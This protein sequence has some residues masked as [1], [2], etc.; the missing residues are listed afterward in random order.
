MQHLP[1]NTG[2]FINNEFVESVSKKK[3]KVINP[4]DETVMCEVAEGDKEDIDIAVSAAQKC[5]KEKWSK[6]PLFERQ[7]LLYKL[8]DL[9][10][11]DAKMLTELECVTNGTPFSLE[12]PV[13][14]GL[15]HTIRYNAGWM[16]KVDGRMITT[17]GTSHVFT[18]YSPLGVCGLVIPWNLPLWTLVVKLAPC[19][20]MG[21]TCV[22]KPSEKT[23]ITAL[24]FAE[25]IVEAGFPPGAVNIV[26]GYGQTAGAAL[27][28]H[29]D[30]RK[31]AFTGSTKV[32]KQ[33]MKYSAE[34]NLK[35]V[36]LELGGK[37]PVIIAEDADLDV[38]V[39]IAC[40][41]IFSNNGEICI[42]GSRTFVHENVYDEFIKKA[43]E[44]MTPWAVGDPLKSHLGPLVDK[45]QFETVLNYIK[46]GKDEGAKLE[47][48]GERQGEKGYFVKPTIFSGVTKE[49]KI[50]KEEIFGPVMSVIK[51][52]S[53][54][55]AVE[56]ANDTEYG[57]AAAIVTKDMSTAFEVSSAIEAGTVWVNTTHEVYDQAPFGGK[58]QSG[59]GKEGGIEGLL[60]WSN[61]KTVVM[62]VNPTLG[63]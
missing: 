8:A 56:M 41:A 17:N 29:M 15:V 42:A 50:C 34:S 31:L 3:F 49:M 35:K 20:A 2:L 1:K 33:I 63:L 18:K 47:F 26:N 46:A 30:V 60:E 13:I 7:S 57:L 10:E 12:E 16:D 4:Q 11:R 24:K 5:Y 32:G 62:K 21:N 44:F 19:L 25:L 48:G 54:K 58:K 45:V 61:V 38:A 22:I 52:K 39:F 51:Y 23:P 53:L 40:A 37:S 43:I 27:A 6:I 14:A 28:K 9:F 36:Q 55:E 59:F